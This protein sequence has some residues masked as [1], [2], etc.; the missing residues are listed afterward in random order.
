MGEEHA[1]TSSAQL[2]PTTTIPNV[3]VTGAL[4]RMLEEDNS[5]PVD[6]IAYALELHS[7]HSTVTCAAIYLE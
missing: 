1:C 7:E 5:Q 3:T 2:L 4:A 6:I